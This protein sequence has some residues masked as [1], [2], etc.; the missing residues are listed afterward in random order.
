MNTHVT[1]GDIALS[2]V[3]TTSVIVPLGSVETFVKQVCFFPD[4]IMGLSKA[5][6]IWYER[7]SLHILDNP[8]CRTNSIVFSPCDE[9]PCLNE[10]NCTQ[11]GLN[12]SCDCSL[13][14][15]GDNCETGKIVCNFIVANCGICQNT[16]GI[17]YILFLFLILIQRYYSNL[18]LI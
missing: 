14:F 11:Q 3:S 10:G 4:I 16:R 8:F 7:G 15:S 12:Y 2:K 9:H 18:P 6:Y 1:M 5:L 17:L 13:G